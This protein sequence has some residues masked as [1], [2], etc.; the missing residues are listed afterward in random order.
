MTQPYGINPNDIFN[1][2]SPEEFNEMSLKIF[3]WQAENVEVYKEFVQELGITPQEVTRIEEIPYLPIQFFKSRKVIANDYESQLRFQSSG[4]TKTGR[5][6]HYLVQPELYEESFLKAFEL[7]YGNPKEYCFLALLPSYLEQ[8]E[9][10]LIYMV[11]RLIKNSK[12][13]SS[14]FFLNHG[15]EFRSVLKSLEN[16]SK[17]LLI[18]VTYALLD[19]IEEGKVKM[20]DL[21]VMETGGMKGRRKELTRDELH[22]QLTNGFGVNSVHSEYGMTELLSQGYSKGEGVFYCPP[23]MKIIAREVNDPLNVLPNGKSGG[24]NIIDLANFY[25]CSFIATQDLGKVFEDGSFEILGRFDHSDVRGCN[26]LVQ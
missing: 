24:V 25:S 7:F 17:V 13:P 5:S 16:N 6:S 14:G 10:S 21:I 26:L 19:F 3:R 20:P 8:Q 4:T 11:D 18:G 12:H 15:V 9:S 23:W 2:Q 22:E 1:I